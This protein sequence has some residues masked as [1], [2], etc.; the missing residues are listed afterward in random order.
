MPLTSILHNVSHLKAAH[1]RIF[2]HQLLFSIHSMSCDRSADSLTA[3]TQVQDVKI[4]KAQ[5]EP[6]FLVST[7]QPVLMQESRAA[8][9]KEQAV[10]SFEIEGGANGTR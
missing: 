4:K 3:S 9:A 2:A 7:V 10:M 5:N 6:A 8:K 1:G